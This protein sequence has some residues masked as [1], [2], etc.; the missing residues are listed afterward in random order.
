MFISS[1]G[2]VTYDAIEAK[3]I[4]FVNQNWG[5]SNKNSSNE[6]IKIFWFSSIKAGNV[7]VYNDKNSH[8]YEALMILCDHLQGLLD[9][10]NGD[11]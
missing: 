5:G 4:M 9:L 1:C 11:L 7:Y 6:K 2:C 8:T 3:E 10:Y